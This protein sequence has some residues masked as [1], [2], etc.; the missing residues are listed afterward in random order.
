[1][2]QG[3]RLIVDAGATKVKWVVCDASGGEEVLVT[4]GINAATMPADAIAAIVTS[5]IVP[6]VGGRRVEQIYYYGAGVTGDEARQ[7]VAAALRLLGDCPMEIESDLAGAAR[8]VAGD[9]KM[10]VGILGTGS[11]SCLYDGRGIVSNI[12]PL[13]FILGDEGS[14]AS[15]GRRLVADA[16][17]GLLPES[18]IALMGLSQA[19]A[20]NRVYRCHA[21]AAW[22]ASW[23]PFIAQHREVP[24]IALIIDSSLDDFT[25]RCL[26]RYGTGLP[27][28]L[29]GSLAVVFEKEIRR[30]L[31]RHGLTLS[32]VVADPIPE[33][34]KSLIK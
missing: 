10:I 18:I 16:L 26:K 4:D 15:M 12:P 7:R 8:A 27:V 31:S 17:K 2:N 25:T 23:V 22:L 9:R 28:G 5:H 13:G 33:L 14:G 34:V 21:P 19:D 30:V 1:M 20:I 3:L 11:N 32:H 29:A 24:E 6:L